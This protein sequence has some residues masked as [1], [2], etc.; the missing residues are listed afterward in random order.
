MKY[1][2]LIATLTLSTMLSAC[3][4]G[5]G[6][7]SF[8]PPTT[9]P[10]NPSN[11]GDV[12]NA[13]AANPE[14]C[15]T[16]QSFSNAERRIELY[17]NAENQASTFSARRMLRAAARNSD[18]DSVTTAYNN[19]QTFLIEGDLTSAT[20]ETLLKSLLLAG[21][22]KKE[23]SYTNFTE[24]KD[25]VKIN[26][27]QIKNKAQMVWDMYGVEREVSIDNAKLN[28]VN[29][30]AKQDSYVQFT[31]DENGKIQKLH[32]DVDM[33]H[34]DSRKM[35][36]DRKSD[37]V[38]TRTGQM[39][40]YGIK[41]E[42]G[43]EV[44][45]ELF[46]KP[47]NLDKLK[48]M[49]LAELHDN[50][51]E[52][53]LH[54]TPEDVANEWAEAGETLINGITSLDA[55]YGRTED[56]AQ[57][58]E[59]YSEGGEVTTTITYTSKAKELNNKKGLQYADF[60]FVGIKGMEG[61]KEVNETFVVAGGMDAK[62]I[63]KDDLIQ[64]QQPMTFEGTAVAT[65]INQKYDEHGE[66]IKE[67][68]DNYDGTANLVFDSGKETLTTDFSKDG[69]YNVVVTS[70]ASQDNYN[71]KFNG[72][73]QNTM[74]KFNNTNVND[75]VGNKADA[76]YGAVDIGYYGETKDKPTE[77][78]GYVAYG[79]RIKDGGSGVETIDGIKGVSSIDL[80]AQIGFG[81]V[82]SN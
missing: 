47:D 21:F 9:L 4:G 10:D 70:N 8:I 80:H 33:D 56:D 65:V 16:S 69:W 46:E 18:A 48:N 7:H 1:K 34:A 81:A 13:C 66:R 61:D 12:T 45:L 44:R 55:F 68:T 23:L 5:G 39:L 31:V 64:L 22:E 73:S 3:G 26:A 20:E 6:G 50:K 77:A 29:I 52:W 35:T 63:N 54:G 28:L 60:G 25:W 40:I 51:K 74:Y 59:A 42:S 19:M 41:L 49:L 14:T 79:E 76:S 78:A 24:L 37:G 67:D 53:L 32:F 17:Q 57:P 30:D 72:E 58:G 71:I 62:R 82:K 2:S 11:P 15:M 36:L 43:E 75:F 27:N 38:F